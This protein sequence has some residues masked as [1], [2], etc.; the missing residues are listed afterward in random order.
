MTAN[1]SVLCDLLL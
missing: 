1:A